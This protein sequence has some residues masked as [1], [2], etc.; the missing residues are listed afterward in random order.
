MKKISKIQEIYEDDEGYIHISLS[1]ERE[2]VLDKLSAW[3]LY[4]GLKFRLE[5]T[6]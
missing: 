4:E 6:T 3:T 1:D 5:G 2:V